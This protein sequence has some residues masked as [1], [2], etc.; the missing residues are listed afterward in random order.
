M[1][2]LSTHRDAVVD[3]L[4]PALRDVVDLTALP[5][6][7][8]TARTLARAVVAVH[9]GATLDLLVDPDQRAHRRWLRALLTTL[10]DHGN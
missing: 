10:L 8:R 7:M 1:S 6:S 5:P 4:V 2:I 3:A 9:D